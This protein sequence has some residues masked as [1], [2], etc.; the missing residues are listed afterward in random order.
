MIG[1]AGELGNRDRGQGLA[2]GRQDGPDP[3][4][5]AGNDHQPQLDL[6]GQPQGT[7]DLRQDQGRDNGGDDAGEQTQPDD[8]DE[9][10]RGESDPVSEAIRPGADLRPDQPKEHPGDQ[11]RQ[12]DLDRLDEGLV[13]QVPAPQAGN[14]HG[15]NA[16]GEKEQLKLFLHAMREEGQGQ[17][18]HHD[19]HQAAGCPLL[20]HKKT[21]KQCFLSFR[22][23]C[24]RTGSSPHEP[25]PTRPSHTP[26]AEPHT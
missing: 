8:D 22:R 13:H 18:Q 6:A 5:K 3:D 9:E 25:S 19:G 4:G 1:F 17:D 2:Q 26:A 20:A 23:F 7:D 24:R 21:L 16:R 10:Q 12:S 15:K 11:D 14:G